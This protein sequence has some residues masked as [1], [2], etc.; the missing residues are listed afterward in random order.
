M[1]KNECMMKPFCNI[2]AQFWSLLKSFLFFLIFHFLLFVFKPKT[3]L[4]MF[5]YTAGSEPNE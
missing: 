2:E 1:T 3:I 4:R 5:A